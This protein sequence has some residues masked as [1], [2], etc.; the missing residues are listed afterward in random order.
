MELVREAVDDR[1]G[2]RWLC[3]WCG[4]VKGR[5][6]AGTKYVYCTGSRVGKG[7][8]SSASSEVLNLPE[9]EHHTNGL[10]LRGGDAN[11]C[12]DSDAFPGQ[13]FLYKVDCSGTGAS[14]AYTQVIQ[15]VNARRHRRLNELSQDFSSCVLERGPLVSPL[16]DSIFRPRGRRLH[17]PS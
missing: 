1:L 14:E 9:I 2:G 8:F 10:G 11:P 3:A 16:D 13:A 15:L 6:A 5:A 7:G 17:E 12:G 4:I